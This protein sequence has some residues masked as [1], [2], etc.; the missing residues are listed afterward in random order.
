MFPYPTTIFYIA[1]VGLIVEADRSKTNKKG[2]D[3][4]KI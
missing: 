1:I 2:A 4:F 3:F